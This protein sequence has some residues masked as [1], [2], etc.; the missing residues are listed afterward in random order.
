MMIKFRKRYIFG[1]AAGA[2]LLVGA[3]VRQDFFEVAKQIE[4]FIKI[5]ALF[6]G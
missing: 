4:I 5:K 1:I 3:G 2:L 6:A